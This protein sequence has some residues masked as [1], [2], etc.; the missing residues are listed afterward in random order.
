MKE[1]VHFREITYTQCTPI[2]SFYYYIVQTSHAASALALLS[3]AQNQNEA[4]YTTRL[5][6]VL[7]RS[8][9]LHASCAL[10]TRNAYD[11]NSDNTKAL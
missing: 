5:T 11:L 6:I 4:K 9:K 1:R 3:E 8:G 2:K 7:V 10:H